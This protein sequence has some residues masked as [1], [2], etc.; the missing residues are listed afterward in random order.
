MA[1]QHVCV[2]LLVTADAASVYTWHKTVKPCLNVPQNGKWTG[3]SQSA[4][5]CMYPLA[6]MQVHESICFLIF[7]FSLF[8]KLVFHRHF[9][10]FHFP[11]FNHA[12]DNSTKMDVFTA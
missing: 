1:R 2:N 3:I 6:Q 11:P 8:I 5:Q 10:S 4:S 7:F 12:S 9:V